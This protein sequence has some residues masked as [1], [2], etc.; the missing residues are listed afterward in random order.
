MNMQPLRSARSLVTRYSAAAALALLAPLVA[1]A[2]PPAPNHTIYGVVRDEMGDPIVVTNAVVILETATG[3]QV[4]TT[5]VPGMA[6]GMN[7]RLRVPMDAGLT[8]DNYKPTA[9]RPLVSFTIKVKI[10]QTTYLPMELH[11][12]FASLGAPAKTTHLD[13]TLGEDSDGDGLPDAW[14]R[15]LIDRMGGKLT[16]ADIKPGAD[17]DGDGLTNLQEYLAGT[18][19]FDPLDGL[20]L[21]MAGMNQ[22]RPQMDFMAIRGRSYGILTSND[23]QNWTPVDFRVVDGGADDSV[24]RTYTAVDVRVVRAEVVSPDGQPVSERAFFKLMA[25]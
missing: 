25:Q 22:G 7:Y 21:T 10:G 1:C 8:S 11:G 23:M 4:K 12:A 14:E 19:A 3:V 6:P 20:P 13:L 2:F 17:S 5:V 16:L 24:M 18:Y 9:L 15:A